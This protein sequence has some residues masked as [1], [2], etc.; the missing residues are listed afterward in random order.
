LRFAILHQLRNHINLFTVLHALDKVRVVESLNS[1][2]SLF[3][4]FLEQ[5]FEERE[6]MFV[7][8]LVF[9][10]LECNVA[11]SVLVENLVVS[12]AREGTHA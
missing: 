12:F 1:T 2:Y 9:W 7:N 6:S 10:S 8:S 5:T 4:V 3:R 11:G